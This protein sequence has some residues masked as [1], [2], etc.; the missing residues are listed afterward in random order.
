MTGYNLFWKNKIWYKL[1]IS[2]AFRCN[3]DILK[4]WYTHAFFNMFLY[5]KKIIE[6]KKTYPYI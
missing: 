5:F 1:N 3:L 4:K 6:N 2:P